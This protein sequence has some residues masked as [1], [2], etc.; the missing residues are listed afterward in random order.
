MTMTLAQLQTL[1]T[2]LTTDPL[3]V[4]YAAIITDHVELAKRVNTAN[5]SVPQTQERPL[6][7]MTSLYDPTELA[8]AEADPAKLRRLQMLHSM[9]VV[10][11][12]APRLVQHINFVFGNPSTTRTRFLQWA[13]RVG[14]RAE[15]LGLPRVTESHVADALLRT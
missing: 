4:G 2:E 12:D 15:E 14:S 3:N 9:P 1:K 7:E 13:V 11:P 5:R 6:W 10:N 8:T